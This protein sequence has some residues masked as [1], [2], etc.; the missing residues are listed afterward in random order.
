MSGKR[1]LVHLF[2]TRQV[3][4]D[5]PYSFSATMKSL[6]RLSLG[7]YRDLVLLIA[8]FIFIDAGVSVINIYTSHQ[9]EDDTIRINAAGEMRS[10]VQQLTKGLLTLD[11]E[12]RSGAI[13]QSSQAEISGARLGFLDAQKKLEEKPG[14]LLKR[15]LLEPDSLGMKVREQLIQISNTWDP[16]EREVA[17]LL[18]SETLDAE[19]VSSAV[20]K[21]VT[22]N[23]RLTRQADDLGLSLEE[24]AQHKT[25][26]MRTIQTFAIILAFLN[27]LFIVFKFIARLTAS[28]QAAAIAREENERIMKGVREGLFLLTRDRTVGSQRSASLD[29]L[30]GDRLKT[31]DNFHQ[32]LSRTCSLE[33]AEAA[34]N[35]IDV[36][37]NRKI[38]QVL[39]EQLN[40]LKEIELLSDTKQRKESTF[41]SFEFDQIRENDEVVALLVSVFDVSEEVRLE[42]ELMN[43]ESRAKGEID[44]LLG[45]LDQNPDTV[46]EFLISARRNLQLINQEL[47][48]VQPPGQ[49]YPQL[50]NRIARTLHGLK[51]EAGT[52]SCHSICQEIHDFEEMLTPL[53]GRAKIQGDDLIPTAVALSKLLAEIA[54]I[55]AIVNRIQQHLSGRSGNQNAPDPLW[56]TLHSIEKYALKVAEDLNKSVRFEAIAP[57]LSKIP[58]PIAGILHEAVPQLIRNAIAHG[59][60]PSDERLTLG[61]SATGLIRIEIANEADGTLTMTVHDDGRGISANYLRTVLIA[62]GFKTP[63][64]VSEMSDEQVIAMLFEPGFSSIDKANLHAGRGDGLG[65]VKAALRELDGRLR[66]SSR[67]NSHT[68]FIMQFKAA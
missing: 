42:R 34:E 33:S 56:E 54:K 41:V 3:Q 18:N 11:M 37:F 59:I 16:I 57:R 20:S 46:A 60:E 55:E 32:V 66:I 67:I 40:P 43:A 19:M 4:H 53:R 39:L 30:F 23:N 22:R 49:N 28:D 7:K 45:V 26:A 8:I 12:M 63:E 48:D 6:P 14:A 2:V 29:K 1:G 15:G 24:L 61:K 10:S 52:L 27:F 58:S 36:L 25:S 44:L 51:G 21:A 64:E 38:K 62:R 31:G 68:R 47:Q 5:L 50:V 17:P 13:T 65:V 9:I 35:Y